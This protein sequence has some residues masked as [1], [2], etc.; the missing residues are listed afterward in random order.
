MLSP[1]A[2]GERDYW[3]FYRDCMC[4]G[5]KR[6]TP[7]RR[8][9]ERCGV[10]DVFP[11]ADHWTDE[12]AKVGHMGFVGECVVPLLAYVTD[13]GFNPGLAPFGLEGLLA[14]PDRSD[15][16][17]VGTQFEAM[18]VMVAC[19]SGMPIV[20]PDQR[21]S[22]G[23]WNQLHQG[24]L[25]EWASRALEWWSCENAGTRRFAPSGPMITLAG[26]EALLAGMFLLNPQASLRFRQE[27]L[28]AD[29]YQKPLASQLRAD[30]HQGCRGLLRRGRDA[31]GERHNLLQMKLALIQAT[32]ALE[33][34][35][36][37]WYACISKHVWLDRTDGNGL[38]TPEPVSGVPGALAELNNAVQTST[39]GVPDLV[40]KGLD[41]AIATL[42]QLQRTELAAYQ[43]RSPP[44]RKYYQYGRGWYETVCRHLE[45]T[46]VREEYIGTTRED[47]EMT[48]HSYLTMALRAP[49]KHTSDKKQ[50]KNP[51]LTRARVELLR[52]RATRA[53][54]DPR[55]IA[56]IAKALKNAG[57]AGS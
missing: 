44:V 22:A 31:R 52:Q 30:I 12:S 14:V 57:M 18:K 29:E 3:S 21:E 34:D 23:S 51:R 7:L 4:G 1:Y 38:P 2:D 24:A 6:P 33:H 48:V 47:L 32:E 43:G 46:R 28:G 42:T 37:L 10:G 9:Y 39:R 20:T 19:A 36:M 45:D 8:L 35:P 11:P 41:S 40:D 54:R 53:S 55:P 26:Y 17:R 15:A 16:H 49:D 13:V 56:Q 25:Q 27:K 50:A 5:R